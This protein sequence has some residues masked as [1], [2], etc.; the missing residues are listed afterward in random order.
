M[1][2]FYSILLDDEMHDALRRKSFEKKESIS[3]LVRQGI[4]FVLEEKDCKYSEDA[5]NEEIKSNQ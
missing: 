3:V 5:K 4:K 2:K 1:S